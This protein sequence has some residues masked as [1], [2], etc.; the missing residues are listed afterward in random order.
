MLYQTFDT[1]CTPRGANEQNFR[2]L[3]IL[4]NKSCVA[5]VLVLVHYIL[6]PM[7]LTT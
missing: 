7:S 5:V 2:R 3:R 6:Y 1:K 4:A